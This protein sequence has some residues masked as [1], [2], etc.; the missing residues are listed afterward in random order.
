[1][2][3]YYIFRLKSDGF[4]TKCKYFDSNEIFQNKV[5]TQ[6]YSHNLG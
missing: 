4:Y 2:G 1:M 5:N 6:I 3:K